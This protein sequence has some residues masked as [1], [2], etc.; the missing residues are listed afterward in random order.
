MHFDYLAFNMVGHT[1]YMVYNIG[2]YSVTSVKEEY[3]RRHPFGANPIAVNDIFFPVHAVILCLIAIVQC[4]CYEVF[5]QFLFTFIILYVCTYLPTC[6]HKV[7]KYL[8]LVCINSTFILQRGTQKVSTTCRI[9]VGCFLLLILD[10][11]YLA[12][13]GTV[14]WLD[15]LY[16]LSMVKIGITLLKYIPQAHFNYQ[17]QSTRGWSIGNVLLDLL[18][19]TFSLAQMFINAWNHG[20]FC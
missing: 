19:G 11:L 4:F 12:I 14:S 15:W 13:F 17:R 9:L 3:Q 2:L 6:V 5:F 16:F 8:Q 20:I 10:R 18:G 1:C 7:W